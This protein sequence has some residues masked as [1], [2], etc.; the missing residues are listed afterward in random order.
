MPTRLQL[1][2]RDIHGFL[3]EHPKRVFQRKEL[4]EI[5]RLERARW[6]LA[7][8]TSAAE[9]LDFL[10]GPKKLQKV[11]M[12]FS[13][14]KEVRYV[15]RS[16]SL[17]EILMTLR[18]DCYFSHFT[19][20]QMH[21]LTEQDAR[22]VHV[23]FEQTPKPSPPGGL[24]QEGIDRAFSRPQR[25][26]KNMA[27][28]RGYRVLLLNGKHTG[29]LGV[30]ERPVQWGDAEKPTAVRLSDLERTLIDLAVRPDYSGG[31]DEVLKAYR[32][33]GDRASANQIAAY[34]QK[35]RYVYPYHQTIGFYMERSE[36][37]HPAAVERFR[38]RFEFEFDFYLAYGLEK[39][40]Y[41]P[42]WR[43]HVPDWM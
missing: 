42:R 40:R 37:F 32:R 6:R 2:Q 31:P 21:D 36:A 18:P 39:T 4:D 34:L 33:A 29:Y 41:D 12:D 8:R 20:M 17:S 30:E 5:V 1:A 14:R 24:S 7:E 38:D 3:D 11:D 27:E 19:A 15:W 22:L 43:L 9:V 35:L 10:T 25:R 28:V 13:W 23:N 16:A 26:A